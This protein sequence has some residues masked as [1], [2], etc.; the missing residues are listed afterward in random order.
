MFFL[1]GADVVVVECAADLP[2]ELDPILADQPVT[3]VDAAGRRL[4][5]VV[6]K[7]GR[8]WWIFQKGPP[9][10]VGVEVVP[11]ADETDLLRRSL[12]AFLES[13]GVQISHADDI[14]IF[15]RNAARHIR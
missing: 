9:E 8:R 14:E 12:S 7:P 4:R 15:A 13:S 2:I 10:I 3:L 6:S 1:D 11:G 5:P